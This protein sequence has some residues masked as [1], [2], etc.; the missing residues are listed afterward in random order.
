MVM[1]WACDQLLQSCLNLCNPMDSCPPGSSVHG[2]L[3]ARILVWVAMTSS[4]ASSWSTFLCHLQWQAGSLPLGPHGKSREMVTKCY[5][6]EIT[7]GL[8]HQKRLWGTRISAQCFVADLME[9]ELGG[10]W[11][12][13][14]VW[15]SPFGVH[16]KLPQHC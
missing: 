3:Q 11:I 15:L 8:L 6:E 5:K 2:I 4:R 7:V 9:R 12:H 10:E 14:Y 16:L 1:Q 13:V